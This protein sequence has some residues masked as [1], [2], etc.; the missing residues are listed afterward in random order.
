M[1]KKQYRKDK[2]CLNCRY[3]VDHKFCPNCGQ[4]NVVTRK[5]FHHL[6]VHFFEDLT[7]YENAFW[8]TIRNLLFKPSAL[9]KEYLSGKRLSYLAP[10]RLYIFISFMTFFLMSLFP[11]E[12]TSKKLKEQPNEE[13]IFENDSGFKITQKNQLNNSDS[14]ANTKKD[15]IALTT[16]EKEI[17]ELAESKLLSKAVKD[18]LLN[19][20]E[21]SKERKI[22]NDSFNFFGYNTIESIDSAKTKGA[23]NK[24]TYWFLKKLIKVKDNNTKDEI[25]DK[26]MASAKSNFPK[27]FFGFFMAKSDGII[28]ITEFLPCIIF[29]FCFYYFL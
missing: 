5:T 27:V 7:H 4:E 14:I 26:G 21:K 10:V 8:R 15:N 16:E 9:T 1:S 17:L 11:D 20:I 19:I 13:V 12:L 18:T 29:R 24:T 2:T 28:L 22:N 23:I 6:F 25:I 3:V